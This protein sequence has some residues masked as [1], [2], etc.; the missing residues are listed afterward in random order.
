MEQS[1]LN[2]EHVSVRY[3]IFPDLFEKFGFIQQYHKL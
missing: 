2:E 3:I 1:E